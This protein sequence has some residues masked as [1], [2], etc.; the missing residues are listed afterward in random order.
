MIGML[1]SDNSMP[2][3]THA[4]GNFICAMKLC[5]R[6][7]TWNDGHFLIYNI[8][9]LLTNTVWLYHSSNRRLAYH[10]TTGSI[11]ATEFEISSRQRNTGAAFLQ[12]SL[13]LHYQSPFYHCSI[14]IHYC[15]VKCAVALIRPYSTAPFI[16]H[17]D[18]IFSLLQSEELSFNKYRVQNVIGLVFIILFYFFI[19]FSTVFIFAS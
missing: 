16:L 12:I 3:S 19:T 14:P 18:L 4:K 5:Q 13:F 15:P 8:F 11:W 17:S 1:K 9:Y 7:A 6:M 10:R 2:G